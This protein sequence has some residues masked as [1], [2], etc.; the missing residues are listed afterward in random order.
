MRA[1]TRTCFLPGGEQLFLAVDGGSHTRFVS[2]EDER[3]REG[4]SVSEIAFCDQAR[5]TRDV[6]V[7]LGTQNAERRTGHCIIKANEYLSFLDL[8][9]VTHQDFLDHAAGRVLDLFVDGFHDD[10]PA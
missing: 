7:E 10:R 9:P 2:A 4:N 3:V 5:T 8:A 6:F 1:L